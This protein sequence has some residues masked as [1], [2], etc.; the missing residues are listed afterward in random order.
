MANTPYTL[1]D[2]IRHGEP[3]G[4]KRYRGQIDDPLSDKGWQ[5][6]RDAVADYKPWHVIVTSP[7]TR[8]A[9][10][11][12]ELAERHHIPLEREEGIKEIRWG[13]WEGRTPAELN[14]EDPLTV[15][16][17][18]RDPLQHRPADAEGVYDFQQR[19]M[20]AWQ[21]ITT[22]HRGKHILI[23]AHAGVVRAVLTHLLQIPAENMF[24]IHVANASVTRIQIDLHEDGP[25]AKVLFHGHNP[26][27]L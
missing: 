13:H 6:M 2:I 20:E 10:F 8:C 4:G 17:A 3:L 18:M 19:I 14:R 27:S 9:A 26:P 25:F 21:D 12:E 7:L 11:A 1:V 16:R 15:L 24:R 23:V 5:Q 22:R